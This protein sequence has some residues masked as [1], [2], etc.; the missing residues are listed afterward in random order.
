MTD[1]LRDPVHFFNSEGTSALTLKH[2][3]EKNTM[4]EA[5]VERLT[6][7]L[8]VQVMRNQELGSLAP[9]AKKQ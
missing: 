7:M 5:E 4:L 2:L 3:L 8:R 6:R 9:T 1:R